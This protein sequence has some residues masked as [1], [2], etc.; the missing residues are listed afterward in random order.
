VATQAP[1]GTRDKQVTLQKIA[2]GSD[3]GFPTDTPGVEYRFF[4][5][6]K[7]LS[8]QE[9]T[10]GAQVSARMETEWIVPYRAEVDPELVDVCQLFRLVY[11]GRTHDIVIASLTSRKGD[12]KLTTTVRVG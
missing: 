4:A 7:D 5:S 10:T 9:R 11:L 1:S 6:K 3:G 12:I 2:A 8:G